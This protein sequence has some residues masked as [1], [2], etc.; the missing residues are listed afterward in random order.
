M[1]RLAIALCALFSFKV[2]VAADAPVYG[3][4]PAWVKPVETPATTGPSDGAPVKVLL[5][6]QQFNFLPQSQE[7]FFESKDLI[8]TAQGLQGLGTLQLP[9]KPDTDVLTIHKVHI[10]RGDQVIDALADGQ[11]FT[12]LRREN[13][14]EYS[15]LDGILTAVFQPADLRVGDIVD[16]AF[17]VKR[18]DP[19]LAGAPDQ[20]AGEW[21]QRPVERVHLRA[22]WPRSSVVRWRFTDD[23]HDL[24]EHTDGD[25][26]EV[27]YTADNIEPPV[28]A[29]GAPLRFAVTRAVE[30]SGFKSWS[31]V[32]KR[33]APLFTKAATLAPDSALKAEVAR[34]KS[35]AHTPGDLAT[36]ALRLVEDDVRYVYLGMNEGGIVP[37]QADLT[38]SR[39]FGDCKA[40]TVLLIA[41]L[42]EL[43]IDAEPVAVSTKIGDGLDARLPMVALFDHV[44]VRAHIG[45]QV[46]WL[47][48]TRGADHHLQLLKTPNYHWGLPLLAA[49][50]GLIPIEAAPLTV[51]T[52][53]T[54]IRID[55]S[56]GIDLPAPMHVES[57]LS[58]DEA[59]AAKLQLA[60]LTG[61]ALERALRQFWSKVYDFVDIKSVSAK[62]DDDTETET[63]TMDGSAHM[64]WKDQWYETNGLGV[65]YEARFTRDAGA[66]MQAPYLVPFPIY[67]RTSETI[68]LPISVVPFTTSGSEVNRVVAGIEYKR[69]FSLVGETFTAEASIRSVQPEFPAIEATEAQATL[70]AM[71]KDGL[72]LRGNG[73]SGPT[74]AQ[75]SNALAIKM[76][77]ARDYVASGDKLLNQND[78]DHAIDDFNKALAIDPKSANA[79]A[80][81][82]MAF[83][84][85]ND[86]AKAT[87][88]WNAAEALD[89]QNAVVVGGRGVMAYR[90]GNFA[91]AVTRL[92]KALELSPNN[93]FDL[94]WRAFAYQQLNRYTEAI[95][96]SNAATKIFSRDINM[97]GVR[98]FAHVRI[99]QVDAA[100]ADAQALL[101]VDSGAQAYLAAGEIY[102]FAGKQ[103]EALQAFNHAIEIAPSEQTYLNRARIRLRSDRTGSEADVEAAL[104]L[105]GRSPVGLYMKANNEFT[106]GKYPA[107]LDT[108]NDL[109]RMEGPK[110]QYVMLRLQA[111][112]KAGQTAALGRDMK[113]ARA[114][115]TNAFLLNDYCWALA[116]ANME[117]SEALNACEQAVVQAPGDASLLDSKAFVLLRL[118]R[119]SDSIATYD[120]ALAINPRLAPSLYGRGLAK[121]RA[122]DTDGSRRDMAAALDSNKGVADQFADYGLHI[123]SKP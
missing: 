82:G 101:A 119:F 37:A 14:L 38:W 79:L 70:R 62:F 94:H 8:Q 122:G 105:N 86:D 68:L 52:S 50:S 53:D 43:G 23:L 48:G 110:F 5:E 13:N 45:G 55:A 27:T 115:A 33:L 78:F 75:I 25:F 24:R 17:S 58:G 84:W 103:D 19:I 109:I 98:A 106:D 21:I 64:V 28:Q 93:S 77:T 1:K 11:K 74:T 36:A 20:V 107:A 104:R 9:W 99:G 118:G 30:F 12:L 73:L 26:T 18:T 114:A 69:K 47:D 96:D 40:K 76:P 95:A 90:H 39:R 123:E 54:H 35:V 81:R 89:P 56:A 46:Y 10:I 32:S 111:D 63:V 71:A 80:G 22:R 67:G 29:T 49:G 31:D 112:A 108:L 41:L 92:T 7:S 34:I 113:D 3:P 91:D 87:T 61:D 102:E 2:A 85:K 83:L 59:I 97:Y 66:N 72:Y 51:P 120:A 88:D 42:R 121:L 60:S 6:D 4:I 116:T 100:V 117:L 16:V 15:A 57:V 44:I 65:G